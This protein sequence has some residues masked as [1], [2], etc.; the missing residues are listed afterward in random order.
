LATEVGKFVI[1][2]KTLN[3]RLLVS[4]FGKWKTVKDFTVHSRKLAQHLK[5]GHPNRKL[6]F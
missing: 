4:G 3:Q 5:T 6:V 1:F 2:V